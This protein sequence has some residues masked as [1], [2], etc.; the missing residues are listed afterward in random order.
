[1]VANCFQGSWSRL[2][3]VGLFYITYLSLGA[4]MFAKIEGPQEKSLRNDVIN[5][6][7]RFL[8]KYD[9]VDESEFDELLMTL[10]KAW[11]FG[12]P[13]LYSNE[14]TELSSWDFGAAFFFSTTLL[15][16]IG[17][18]FRTVD[19]F[20]VVVCCW[21]CCWWWC[22]TLST[23]MKLENQVKNSYKFLEKRELIW[24]NWSL[25]VIDFSLYMM[26]QSL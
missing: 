14:T 21:C 25:Q 20:L 19:Y 7:Q 16:T 18:S 2:L 6:K 10:R 26:R 15:T 17:K 5:E 23:N 4:L 3:C 22:W 9:C 12:L 1:M 24:R 13:I 11:E 8:D